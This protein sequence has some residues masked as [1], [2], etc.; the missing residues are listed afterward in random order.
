MGD[1][2]T[3]LSLALSIAVWR[4]KK[5]WGGVG[6]A[7]IKCK[8]NMKTVERATSAIT[9]YLINSNQNPFQMHTDRKT[10]C[11]QTMNASL[12]EAEGCSS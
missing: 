11:L 5:K 1:D 6:K 10:L 4:K 2:L 3:A 12:S 9:C 8:F 7:K